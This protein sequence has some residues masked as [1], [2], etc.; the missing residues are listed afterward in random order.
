MKIRVE[1]SSVTGEI[2]EVLFG[3]FSWVSRKIKSKC[4]KE[5]PA[6]Y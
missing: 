1:V 4:V 2:L 5:K 3:W 6:T